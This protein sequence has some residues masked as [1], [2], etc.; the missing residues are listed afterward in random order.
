[1]YGS[2][3]S[4][5]TTCAL[6]EAFD[7]LLSHPGT[8][9]LGVRRTYGEIEKATWKDT[10]EFCDKFG[11]GY[12]TNKARY[13]ITLD[14][15]SRMYFMSA[16]KTATSKSDKANALG[17]TQFS[18]VMLDEA[19]EIPYEFALTISGR[20]REN[21]GIKRPIILYICNPPSKDHWLY[22]LFFNNPNGYHPEDPASPYRAIWMP[23]S[24]NREN[25]PKN[26]EKNIEEA[27][28]HNPA[29]HKRM[30]EGR[31]GPAVKGL[32]IFG[33]TFRPD[34]HVA[35]T[36]IADNWNKEYPLYRCWDFGWR[37]PACVVFQDDRVRGQIRIF[38]ADLGLKVILERFAEDMLELHE[39]L[40]PGARWIDVA[41]IA[42]NQRSDKTLQTSMDILRS[43]GLKPKTRRT[44]ISY[45][46]S[47]ISEQL[48]KFNPPRYG[49]AGAV[50]ALVVDPRCNDMIEGFQ[51]GYCAD[52]SFAQS[53]ETSQQEIKPNKDGYYEHLFD[54]L[55]YGLVVCRRPG[56]EYRSHL[57]GNRIVDH[58]DNWQT[59]D[60]DDNNKIKW[61][62]QR[63]RRRKL[64]FGGS[65][66]F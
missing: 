6:A 41:D 17:G 36:E 53:G 19:D 2:V 25:L 62:R 60:V 26:Y 13:E 28:R 14:N 45:G 20:M 40:F 29:A 32:P 63:K 8:T 44:T 3:G 15:G 9:F 65:Y 58:R 50:P 47:V 5:K 27:Y 57:G 21:K 23:T 37:R 59:V 1:M 52:E 54:A 49:V 33:S 11:I 35:D 30:V 31:F 51:Y 43:F 64:R 61:D 34:L 4:G 18:V 56:R 66:N 16:E 39:G 42:G 10:L 48:R 12:K 7:I 38:R 24:A 55:R 46:L 22:Q